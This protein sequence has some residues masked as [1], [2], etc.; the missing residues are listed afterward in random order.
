[1]EELRATEL[2]LPDGQAIL[3]AGLSIFRRQSP[4]QTSLPF[5]EEGLDLLRPQ[6]VTDLLKCLRVSTGEQAVVQCFK[7]NASLKQLTFCPFVAILGQVTSS[8]SIKQ[9]R[10]TPPTWRFE[11]KLRYR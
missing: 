4:R 9:L 2:D 5:V 3:V 11:A 6:L 1:M 7:G 8:L 10:Q